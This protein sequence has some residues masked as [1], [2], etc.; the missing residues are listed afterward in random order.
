[1]TDGK[2]KP[3]VPTATPASGPPTVAE[4]WPG[5]A[6]PI[7]VGA[8][9]S[10]RY[11]LGAAIGRGGMGEVL[12]AT[13]EQIG[14]QVAVKRLR[15]TAPEP[16]TLTRFLRE[17]R[18]QG[19]LEHPAVVP[20]HELSRDEAGRPFFV[21]KQ[22]AGVTLADVL[23][24]LAAGDADAAR[25]YPRQR[26]LRAFTEV[27]LAIEFAH[28]RGVVHRDVK[29]WNIVLGDFGE[30]YL[31][32]WGVARVVGDAPGRTTFSD[33]D[34]ADDRS[35]GSGSAV[36]GDGTGTVAGVI[37]GTPGYISPEQIRG[38]TDLDHRA[39]VY[40]LGCIL[41]EM[42]ALAP[43]HPRGAESL[44]SAL[45]GLAG[46]RP[47]VR[48]PARDVP[49][50]LDLIC[51]RATALDRADRYATARELGDAV[52]LFLDG[53]R[54]VGLRRDIAQTELAIARAALASGPGT[55][56]R[57]AAIRA[58]ARALALDPTAREPAD[59][60]GRLMLEPPAETPTDVAAEL[61]RQD[62]V[63]LKS[64]ARFGTV[65]AI[66]YVMFLPILYWIGF[67][68]PWV[69]VTGLALCVFIIAVEQLL[70]PRNPFWSGYLAIAGHLGVIV[71]F[72][73]LTTPVLVGVGPAVI[74]VM[75][76]AHHPRL[77]SPR[78]LALLA[79]VATLSP[80]L[81]QL[82]GL[83]PAVVSARGSDYVLHT[84]AGALDPTAT[85]AATILYFLA[86]VGL[87]LFLS[88]SQE[89]E[90]AE[91]RRR[92]QIQAWLLR[93]LVPDEPAA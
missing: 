69:H 34:T 5:V 71:L 72:S 33:I 90:R 52:Q 7:E 86:V 6:D 41:F 64:S 60:I 70:A 24:R 32:D 57:R 56:Q 87:A 89:R 66:A 43:L 84:A 4:T 53:D 79:V 16:I 61:E 20:V 62:I 50:E 91:A 27:C 80:W 93:Q 31:L 55:L 30:V 19:R 76:M 22:L 45:G 35:G 11:R 54:D 12:S 8:T 58:A 81:L 51:V 18:I 49:P 40:A 46:A 23:A 3:E 29:P 88:R 1:M 82:A 42:L 85:I 73:W 48:A 38:D 83:V 63:A 36:A 44:A 65:A 47:S 15:A 21:M 67:R 2:D 39:D 14:R 10:A 26:L 92:L 13:D 28:T 9:G 37:L 17:A 77:I 75:L 78:L 25:L 68:Q 74:M 59:L